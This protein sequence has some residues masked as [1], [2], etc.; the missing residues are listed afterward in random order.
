MPLHYSLKPKLTCHRRTQS[1]PASP[2]C[3]WVVYDDDAKDEGI[4]FFS[5]EHQCSLATTFRS[6]PGPDL[7]RSNDTVL[8]ILN[9]KLEASCTTSASA[10]SSRLFLIESAS[11]TEL[12]PI[13]GETSYKK[14]SGIAAFGCFWRGL[15]YFQARR[16]L[17]SFRRHYGHLQDG[18]TVASDVEGETCSLDP[19]KP[20]VLACCLYLLAWTFDALVRQ[21]LPVEAA[22][23]FLRLRV[24]SELGGIFILS[25]ILIH[26]VMGKKMLY[27][28]RAAGLVTFYSL[29]EYIVRKPRRRRRSCHTL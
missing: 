25:L 5:P 2:H 27:S 22:Q 15:H 16:R 17:A 28:S 29:T 18:R 21:R 23:S 3:H 13:L 14:P 8:R 10:A 12:P 6:L 26:Y 24:R 19:S 20:D 4:A 1:N 7:S 9:L 11:Q